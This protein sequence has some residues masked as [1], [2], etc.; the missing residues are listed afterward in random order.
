MFIGWFSCG[1]TSAVACKL[2]VERFGKDNVDLWYLETGGHHPD[3]VRF[4]KECEEWIGKEI[5]VAQNPKYTCPLDVARKE[6][7]TTPYGAPCTKHLKKEVRQKQ[8]MPL[9]GDDVVH[10]LGFE[11]TKH[12]INRALRWK[13]QQT[14]NC[15][16]PLIE[17]RMNKQ[18]CLLELRKARI[19]IP[20]MYKLGYHNNNCIGCFKAGAGYWNKIRADFPDV[21]E[22]VS[23]VEQ[24]T[25][26][27]V[28]KR[29]GKP[30]Y[31]KDL[32]PTAGNHTDLE[33]PDC[34]LFCDIEMDG[35][36]VL[37]LEDA[38]KQLIWEKQ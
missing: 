16:F 4:R 34:G 10:V 24:E 28:L 8:I 38:R 36:P 9:Y 7:F 15:Y 29:D 3:N 2:A 20:A 5:R 18:D 11:Y 14:P 23:K 37:E 13:E 31:L 17:K 26:H 33:I 30:L 19:E 21:F 22:E 1:S 6:L 12:E 35:L 25:K 27:T 32:E